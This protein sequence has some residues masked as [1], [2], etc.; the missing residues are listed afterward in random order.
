M[1]KIRTSSRTNNESLNWCVGVERITAAEAVL[2]GID[3]TGITASEVVLI[4]DT[5]RPDEL[6]KVY[7]PHEIA[8]FLLGAKDGEFDDMVAPEVFAEVQA[9]QP[10]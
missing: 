2:R 6:P 4:H 10:S 1:D 3:L 8:A 7:T 9:A 5:K